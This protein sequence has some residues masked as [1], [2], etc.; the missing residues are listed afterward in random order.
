[1]RFRFLHAADLHLD[2]PLLGLS[3][4]SPEFAARIEDASRQAFDNLVD[5]ALAED[6]RLLVVAGDAFDR[7]W[8]DWRTGRFFV[9]RLAR[10]R[11][12]GVKVVMIL[13]NH[14]AQNGLAA[15]L[16]ASDNFTLF[17]SRCAQSATFDDF[18]A[19][20]HGRS[21][22][23]R[24]VAENIALDYPPPLPG[25]FNIGVLHTC[26]TGREGH[27]PYAP[28]TVEQLR[29]HG[30]QYWALG[31]VHAREVLCEDPPILY[32]GNLQARHIRETGAKGATLVEVEDGAVTRLEHR[33]LDVARFAHERIEIGA[34]DG[35][36]A[37]LALVVE[38][39]QAACAAAE[40]RALALRVELCGASPLHAA[41]VADAPALREE[42]ETTFAAISPDLWLEKLSLR[43]QALAREAK[44]DP[45]VAGGLREAIEEL[46]AQGWLEGRLKERLSRIR[47]K[48]PPNAH[49]EDL[50][51]LMEA[52][53]AARA[54]TLAL[55]LLERGDG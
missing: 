24:E 50:T 39:A 16:E 21:F 8:R 17:S 15:R 54:R 55:A 29:N 13:G 49:G 22:P 5:L 33:A 11:E 38:R 52:E 6:C 25:Y 44:V 36:D 20:A 12:G 14:D 47:A 4:K 1:M 53:G 43:T 28:C 26:A 3:A 23:N 35:R 42:I 10:L 46:Y 30:Y 32:S 45:S 27:E 18:G 51:R 37:L 48:L 40:G 2:S 41:L 9:E 31:H 7:D 34:I 19:A